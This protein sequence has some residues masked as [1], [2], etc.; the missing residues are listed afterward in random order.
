MARSSHFASQRCLRSLEQVA[1]VISGEL[2]LIFGSATL[3]Q[4]Q[5]VDTY[6]VCDSI[7][8]LQSHFARLLIPIGYSDR[9]YASIQ[10]C[11]SR[12]QQCSGKDYEIRQLDSSNGRAAKA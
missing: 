6:L 1:D 7:H 12:C 3:L 9:M 8:F 4:L 2:N 11:Q 5:K 10:Q